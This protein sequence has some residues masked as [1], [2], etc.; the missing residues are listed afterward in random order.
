M[1][2]QVHRRDFTRKRLPIQFTIGE[3]VF[4]CHKALPLGK[5]QEV[6][7][8]LGGREALTQLGEVDNADR[9]SEVLTKIGGIMKIFMK[10]ASYGRF[11]ELLNPSDDEL[12]QEDYEPLDQTQLT[13]IIRWLIELYTLRPT[14]PSPSSSIGLSDGTTGTS[15]TAGASPA[16]SG[17]V[18][19][20][21]PTS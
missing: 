8:A 6:M 11:L 20:E 4:K 21:W 16:D 5:I 19:L 3:D 17:Q 12:N 15:S 7:T 1:T 18:T 9:A 14:Q 2:Q 10:P 13:D